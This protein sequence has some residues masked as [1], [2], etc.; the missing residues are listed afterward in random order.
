MKA[1]RAE[2]TVLKYSEV[3]GLARVCT[4]A[5][6]FAAAVV[7]H[8]VATLSAVGMPD[9]PASEKRRLQKLLS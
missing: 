8:L 4:L 3:D 9:C 6:S 7:S 1:P 5:E 2:K